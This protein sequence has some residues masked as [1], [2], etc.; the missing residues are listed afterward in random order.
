MLRGKYRVATGGFL[1]KCSDEGHLVINFVI[2]NCIIVAQSEL[3]AV[4]YIYAVYI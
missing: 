1:G 3:M 2:N 4:T